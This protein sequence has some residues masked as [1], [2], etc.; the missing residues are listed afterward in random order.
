M[1]CEDAGRGLGIL[2]W[3]LV[4]L[5]RQPT[6]GMIPTIMT[7]WSWAW[8]E[9]MCGSCLSTAVGTLMDSGWVHGFG[10]WAARAWTSQVSEPGGLPQAI[11]KDS[12]VVVPF[13]LAS[14]EQAPTEILGEKYTKKV[15][16][17]TRA[18][19]FDGSLGGT[20]EKQLEAVLNG[21]GQRQLVPRSPK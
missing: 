16:T 9:L 19:R 12:Q 20:N 3:K 14:F 11:S 15:W 13:G 4:R 5:S 6:S 10:L 8:S 2:S 21:P 17:M 1:T 18:R 7:N